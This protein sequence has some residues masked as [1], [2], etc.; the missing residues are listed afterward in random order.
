[1]S[2]PRRRLVRPARVPEGPSQRQVQKLRFKLDAQRQVLARW[3]KRLTRA[4]NTVIKTQQHITR[5]ERQLALLE[6]SNHA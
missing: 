5:Y 1:M 4:I 3:M 6:G 2:A